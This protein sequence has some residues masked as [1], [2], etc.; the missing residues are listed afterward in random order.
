[1]QNIDETGF[2]QLRH[3]QR[4]SKA[5][6]RLGSKAHAA[7]RDRVYVA[8]EAETGKVVEQI[9]GKAPAALEPVDLFG[10]KAQRFEIVERILEPGGEQKATPRGQPAHKKLKNRLFS[11]AAVQ[12]G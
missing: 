10:R 9:V 1:M 12:V 6:Q 8:G 4:R 2:D 3:R 7:F 11:L 5:Q